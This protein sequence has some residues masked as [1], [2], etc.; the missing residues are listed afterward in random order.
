MAEETLSATADA[1]PKKSGK[2]PLVIAAVVSLAVG[3]GVGTV[4]LAPR[5]AS[6]GASTATGAAGAHAVEGAHKGAADDT[7]DAGGHETGGEPAEAPLHEIENIVL[8]PA[9]TN[10]SRYLLLTVALVLADASVEATMKARDVEVRDRII[11]LLATRTIDE[12]V[13]PAR[14]DS[15]K[16]SIQQA[17][18]P[19][20]PKGTIRRVLLPQFVV[21]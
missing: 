14:R 1:E 16:I 20:F 19:L 21:Q 5:V 11:G 15:I 9:G 4:V 7:E 10:G 2:L 8:N 18:A 3:T 13:D 6:R 12:L 17:V